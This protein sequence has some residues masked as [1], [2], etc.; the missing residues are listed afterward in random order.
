MNAEFIRFVKDKVLSMSTQEG[1]FVEGRFE[2][3]LVYVLRCYPCICIYRVVVWVLGGE[4]SGL[5]AK[6]GHVT[7]ALLKA[8]LPTTCTVTL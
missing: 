1:K 4:R 7:V 6:N 2:R 8:Q 3:V 5:E